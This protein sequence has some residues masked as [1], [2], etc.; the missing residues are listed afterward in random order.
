[1]GRHFVLMQIFANFVLNL[2]DFS[3]VSVKIFRKNLDF[4]ANLV[5]IAHL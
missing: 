2:V 4:I 5:L 3:D 1:M